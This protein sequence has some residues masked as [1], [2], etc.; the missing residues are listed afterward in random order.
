MPT[1]RQ[2]PDPLNHLDGFYVRE[3]MKTNRIEQAKLESLPTCNCNEELPAMIYSSE[4]IHGTYGMK[5]PKE[6]S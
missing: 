1:R 4:E 5:L 3:N 6:L 2:V